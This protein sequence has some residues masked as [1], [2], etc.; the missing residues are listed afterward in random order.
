MDP[1]FKILAV[2]R[3]H[4]TAWHTEIEDR[5]MATGNLGHAVSD[6]PVV[7]RSRVLVWLT[8]LSRFDLLWVHYGFVDFAIVQ[9]DELIVVAQHFK[10]LGDALFT[11]ADGRDSTLVDGVC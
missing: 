10:E 6:E 7:G 9:R 2:F 11:E 1:G 5:T 4:R 3:T 8:R